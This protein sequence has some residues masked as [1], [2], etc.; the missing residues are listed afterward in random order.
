MLDLDLSQSGSATLPYADR[1]FKTIDNCYFSV[2]PRSAAQRPIPKN[3]KFWGK[4]MLE[5]GDI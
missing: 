3:R 5:E 2:S 1:F 4:S